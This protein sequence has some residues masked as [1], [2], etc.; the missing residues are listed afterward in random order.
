MPIIRTCIRILAG[1]VFVV[2]ISAFADA[3]LAIPDTPAG[4]VLSAWLDAFNSGDEARIDAFVKIYQPPLGAD[5]MKF[6]RKATGGFDVLAIEKSDKSTSVFRVKE[7]ASTT[8]ALGKLALKESQPVTVARL[9]LFV[10]A[11]NEKYTEYVLDAA[12]RARVVDAAQHQLDDFYVFPDAAKKMGAALRAHLKHGDYDSIVDGGIFADKLTDDLR[13][14]SH[15][16]H[17]SIDFSPQAHPEQ[18]PD[19]KEKKAENDAQLRKSM[20]HDNCGFEKAEHLPSNIGYL[21]F[22][23]FA[24]ADVCGPTAVAAMNF[25]GDSDA[26]IFD[27]RENGGGAPRM[28]ALISTYLFDNPT[29]LN[30]LYLRKENTTDQYWTLPYV[31]GKR[32]ADK[33]VYVLTSKNTFSGAEEFSYNLKNLKRATLIGETTGGGAHPVGGHR[34][35]DH[36]SINVPFARAINPVSKTNW[37]GTGVE[38]DVKVPAADALDTAIKLAT[39][40]LGESQTQ[41]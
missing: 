32:L 15:D 19:N 11:P 22:N 27:L 23:M 30:D 3:P 1:L 8:Q 18:K 29:H 39:Q 20:A 17:L 25:L 31:P 13:G 40:K 38:P 16:K 35:D 6:F 24:P 4:R 5:Q 37:E 41:H 9:E 12:E 2:S 21:K 14:I 26:I 34:I 36:F 10:A 33:P 28:I 7:K